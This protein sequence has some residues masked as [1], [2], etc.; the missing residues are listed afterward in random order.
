[1]SR[2][3]S[4]TEAIKEAQEEAMAEDPNVVLV[5]LGVNY[6]NGADGTSGNLGELY[7]ERVLDI[8]VS[9]NAIGGICVGVALSEM[10]P[11]FVNGRVEFLM[12][13]ADS[14]VSQSSK[15]L[16]MFGKQGGNVPMV[17][18]TAIGRGWG[19]GFQHSSSLYGFFGS[20]TGI[21]VVI[22][23]TPWMAKS[24]LKAALKSDGPVVFLEPRWCYGITQ[25]VFQEDE[26]LGST[27][28]V[29]LEKAKYYC[30]GSDI[31][32]V[33]AGDALIDVIR[34]QKILEEKG[35]SVEIIDLVSINPIDYETIHRSTLKTGTLLCVEAGPERFGYSSEVISRIAQTIKCRLFRMTAPHEACPPIPDQ[36]YPN[37]ISIADQ[38]LEIF[39]MEKTGIT[40]SFNELNLPPKIQ[41]D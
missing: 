21:N 15:W 41:I 18:R 30:N 12:V 26:I 19:Q 20:L 4:F 11:I 32:I 37:Y 3:L 22:P 31:T 17:F 5:G 13:A 36:Y 39:Y 35:I 9:E 33:A 24:L 27:F 23:S 6:P 28:P 7:P 25:E 34:A 8:P 14:L 10:R 40:L 1:M 2:I 16:Q 29:D 38:V